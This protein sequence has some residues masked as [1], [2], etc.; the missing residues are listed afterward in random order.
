MLCFLMLLAPF[1]EKGVKALEQKRFLMLLGGM[2]IYTYIMRFFSKDNSH[3]IIF[4][5][6]IYMGARY[7]K[8]YPTS[9]LSTIM[10]RGGEWRLCFC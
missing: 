7:L 10:R 5:L 8:N 4:F 2:V 1:I 6:T 3:D 9:L